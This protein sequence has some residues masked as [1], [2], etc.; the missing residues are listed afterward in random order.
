MSRIENI[1]M[2]RA[3]LDSMRDFAMANPDAR[4]KCVPEAAPLASAPIDGDA[5]ADAIQ[6]LLRDAS[7][8]SQASMSLGSLSQTVR[9]ALGIS[10]EAKVELSWRG[11]EHMRK[12]HSA[13][14]LDG[15]RGAASAVMDCFH[16]PGVLTSLE[17]RGDRVY[18]AF[19]NPSTGAYGAAI[20]SGEAG[21]TG[22]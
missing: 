5:K 19:W 12:N 7:S 18:L 20:K 15:E 1:P 9:D 8:D 6:E 16:R 11:V 21:T 2:R 22:S 3:V 10:G 14:L 17:M 4:I 13:T